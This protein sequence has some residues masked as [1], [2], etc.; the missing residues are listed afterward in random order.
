MEPKPPTMKRRNKP[1][2]MMRFEKGGLVPADSYAVS[3]IRAKNYRVGDL[4]SCEF[5]KLN[6]SGFHR[7]VH[8]IG[9]LCARH[10]EAFHGMDAHKVLK[11]LQLEGSIHCEEM[12]IKLDAVSY[13]VTVQ[14]PL[15]LDFET[16]D[17]GERH[18]V[19]RSFCRLIAQKYWQGMT[20]EA[21]EEMAASFIEEV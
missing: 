14:V 8:W 18:E 6:N 16:L 9:V 21:I 10:I 11:R 3:Q 15:S 13:M 17:D 1:T 4:V 19:A 2:V 5:K 20:P 7:L 12:N